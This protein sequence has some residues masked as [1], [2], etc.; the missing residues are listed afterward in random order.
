MRVYSDKLSVCQVCHVFSVLMCIVNVSV[1]E[2]YIIVLC[3][4]Y[5]V[6]CLLFVC[7]YMS[8]YKLNH[9]LAILPVG[10]ELV[11]GDW[12]PQISSLCVCVCMRARVCV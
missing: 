7:L 4:S 12:N 3:M 10:W 2:M 6:C 8:V 5:F 1:G 9:I 11:I